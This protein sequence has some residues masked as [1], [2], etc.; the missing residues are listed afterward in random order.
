MFSLVRWTDVFVLQSSQDLLVS[1]TRLPEFPPFLAE[2][3]P[4]H[5]RHWGENL[6]YSIDRL[7]DNCLVANLAFVKYDFPEQ[8]SRGKWRHCCFFDF[9][10]QLD[11]ANVQGVHNVH[12]VHNFES[13]FWPHC[14]FS[15]ETENWMLSKILRWS[16]L[17]VSWNWLTQIENSNSMKIVRIKLIVLSGDN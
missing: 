6:F 11:I 1:C 10:Q 7:D 12:F 5:W 14:H 8:G 2:G 17:A 9:F 13:R 16:N 3:T 4:L 15:L